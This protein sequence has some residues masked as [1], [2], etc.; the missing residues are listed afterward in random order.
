MSQ[1]DPEDFFRQMGIDY[2]PRF[3]PL[4]AGLLRDAKRARERR[5]SLLKATAYVFLFLAVLILCTWW[6]S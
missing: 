2:D 1:N 6:K 3:E 5:K 4:R